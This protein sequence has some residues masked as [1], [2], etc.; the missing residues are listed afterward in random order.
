MVFRECG[1]YCAL[2][3]Q[4]DIPARADNLEVLRKELIY[5]LEANS[6]LDVKYGREPLSKFKHSPF[7]FWD[8]YDKAEIDLGWARMEKLIINP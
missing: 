5:L 4:Y 3:L 2:C 7:P 6:R 8:R 1:E